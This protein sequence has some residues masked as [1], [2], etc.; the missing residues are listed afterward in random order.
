MERPV[1]CFYNEN[2]ISPRS[3]L[4]QLNRNRNITKLYFTFTLKH[5]RLFNETQKQIHQETIESGKFSSF[6][7]KIQVKSSIH[8]I[9]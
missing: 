1:Y 6:I 3:M 7:N 5:Y 4:Q 8:Y 9:Q 2:T